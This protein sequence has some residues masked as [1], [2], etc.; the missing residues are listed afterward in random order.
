M[1]KSKKKKHKQNKQQKAPIKKTAA[2]EIV[3]EEA[4][5]AERAQPAEET[6]KAHEV[7]SPEE[8]VKAPETKPAE[9]KAPK[10]EPAEVKSKEPEVSPTELQ[11]K[12]S[13]KWLIALVIIL[14]LVLLLAGAAAG[15]YYWYVDY[16]QDRFLPN[17][18]IND[19]VCDDLS[20]EQVTA[21]LEAREVPYRLVVTGQNGDQIGVLTQNEIGLKIASPKEGVAYIL[22]QQNRYRWPFAYLGKEVYSHDLLMETEYDEKLA[23]EAVAGWPTLDEAN[24]EAPRD[25]YITKY[26]SGKKGYEIVPETKGNLLDV[27]KAADLI[28]TAVK[29]EATELNLEEEGCYLRAEV[30]AEDEKLNERV[31][32][33]NKLVGAQITYDWNGSEVVVDGETIHKWIVEEDGEITID[34]TLVAD[35]VAQQAKQNDTF[36]KN[37]KFTTSLGETITVLNGGYGWKTDKEKETAEL[38]ALIKEGAVTEKEPVY[39]YKAYKKGKDHVGNSYVEIDLTNQH[40]YLYYKGNLVVETDF[41]SGDV[42]VGNTTPGGLYGLTYKTLNAVLRGRDYVTP[43]QYWMPFNGNIGMHDATWR[44]EFGGDIYLTDG[45]HGCI[46]LP[47]EKAA[48]I[49]PYLSARFPII[50]YYY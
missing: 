10:A 11:K 2:T 4:V 17:T 19:V 8:T 16:Y 31:E 33:L 48:E 43:V 12:K 35:F 3:A 26:L 20:V 7:Q 14:S 15:V 46:N 36:G 40:L 45:S 18:V 49:Y 21:I 28:L 30:T 25:A 37:L 5:K 39:R 24:M 6:V 13:K 1:S 41:V 42:R 27:K 38:V 47:L 34:E 23:A 9:V 29:E 32:A 44:T 50:C 22:K